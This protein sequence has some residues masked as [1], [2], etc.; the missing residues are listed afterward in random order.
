MNYKHVQDGWADKGIDEW[1]K[2]QM[3]ER[4][5]GSNLG[6]G[7]EGRK[8]FF[9]SFF[10]FFSFFL[11]NNYFKRLYLVQKVDKNIFI[12]DLR[13]KCFFSKGKNAFKL[14]WQISSESKGNYPQ[15]VFCFKFNRQI[16][17][18]KITKFLPLDFRGNLC[19]SVDLHASEDMVL[20]LD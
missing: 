7:T 11:C 13:L 5:E 18:T 8:L 15:K 4:G 3:D 20:K 6:M 16:P 19:N 12:S 9:L 1:G 2:E 17:Y 14:W 10:S